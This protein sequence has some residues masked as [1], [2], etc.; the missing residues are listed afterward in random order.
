[1][2]TY[3]Q[4]KHINNIKTDNTGKKKRMAIERRKLCI[5]MCDKIKKKHLRQ[6]L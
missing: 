2:H 1:M 3:I 5:I 4:I 6:N